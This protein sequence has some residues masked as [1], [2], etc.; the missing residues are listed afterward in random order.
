MKIPASKVDRVG[1]YA[2]VTRDCLAS[3]NDRIAQYEI[4]R[5]YY[6]T[7][8]PPDNP[9]AT[10]NKILPQVDLLQAFLFAAETTQFGIVLGESANSMKEMPKVA[11][12]TRYLNGA[13]AAS[14]ADVQVGQAIVWALV[15]GTMLVKLVQ[16]GSQ[17]YPM[18]VDP[19]SF[20]VLREDQQFLDDQDAFIHSYRVSFKTLERTLASHPDR[21]TI[22]RTVTQSMQPETESAPLGVQRILMANFPMV[23][24]PNGPGNVLTPF[25][26]TDP[27]R[28]KV[29]DES[30]EMHELWVWDDETN[31]YRIAT[32]ASGGVCVYDR[33][34]FFL[35]GEGS[36]VQ[37]CPNPMYGYFWGQSEV[38]RVTG[39]QDNRETRMQ[40]VI[41]LLSRQVK[42][43]LVMNGAWG[44][45]PDEQQFALNVFGGGISTQ[46]PSA[47]AIPVIPQVPPDVMAEIRAYDEMFNE[48]MGL[49]NVVQGRGESGVRSKGHA[50]ELARLGSARIRKRAF[51]IEDALDRIGTL[52]LKLAQQ[53]DDRHMRDDAGQQFIAEQFT[54]DFEVKVD[55]HSSSP[56]F[57]EDQKSTAFELFKAGAISKAR[58]VE[59]VDPPK[60]QQ[61]L[62]DL[63]KLEAARQKAQEAAAAAKGGGPKLSAAK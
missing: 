10:F 2:D 28:S 50:A 22:M 46:D 63:P 21:D 33:E 59:M 40:Q 29:T 16:R 37:V 13:W 60:K 44:G 5:S 49:S 18:L 38:G 15:Y 8:A 32:M 9:A 56:I 48:M 36:F 17:T 62:A 35:P 24:A 31:D 27:Y 34:N 57:V 23:N 41:E 6:L 14:N 19:H 58:L 26:L 52:Y 55:A 43:P 61:I 39:I 45:I 3:R 30:V 42:P 11:P 51:T 4:W 54:K 7:G 47:K 53:H 25:D 1:F 12:L 20:G